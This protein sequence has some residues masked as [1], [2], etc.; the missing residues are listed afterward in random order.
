[1]ADVLSNFRDVTRNVRLEKEV[2]DRAERMVAINQIVN[3][4]NSSIEAGRVY[5]NLTREVR[6]LVNFDY[7]AVSLYMDDGSFETRQL[8]PEPREGREQFPRMDD[9]E[10]CSGWV[11]KEKRCLLIPLLEDDASEFARNFPED[12]RSCLCVPLHAENKIIGS[13]NFGSRKEAGF[14]EIDARMLEQMSPHLAA[15]IRNGKLLEDL[16]RTLEEATQAR[17]KLHAANEE[18]KSLDEM[19][20]NLLSNVS[21]ELRT[22]LVAVMGYTDMVLNGK[23]GP[24]TETQREYLQITLRNV[25][26]LVSLIENLLDFSRLHKGTEEMVFTRFNLVDCIHASMQSVKPVADG[27]K[28]ELLLSIVNADNEEGAASLIVEGDKGKLGQVFNNLLANAVKFN[29]NGGKVSVTIEVRKDA[30]HIAVSDTG[31][32]IEENDLD[33]VFARFYQCDASSTRK[34]GGTG[35]G[36]AIAQDIIRLHGSRITV[37]SKVGEGST[38]RFTLPLYMPSDIPG[39]APDTSVLPVETRLLVEVV[40]RDKALSAQIRNFLQSEGMDIIHAL[41]AETALMM[42]HKY[43][44]DCILVDTEMDAS[45]SPVLDAIVESSSEIDS[46]IIM[47]TDD[48]TLYRKYEGHVVAHVKRSFRK[49]TLLSGIH[50][51][52]SHGAPKDR[53]LG[54]KILCVDDDEEI[55]IF[56]ARCL[57]NEGYETE[58]CSTGERALAL[59]ATREYWLVLL[60]V[61]IPDMDGWTVCRN[62]KN[63]ADLAGIKVYI[64]TAKSVENEAH[65]IRD[66]EADGYLLKPFKAD[67]IISVVRA[68][69][70]QSGYSRFI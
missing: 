46:A 33:K 18:L 70:A 40:S 51:A 47:I 8:W 65:E 58:Y 55:G 13:L 28:I 37:T 12:I 3:V 20:T 50:L 43:N 62:L 59:A 1:M 68:F 27:R 42:I 22:P 54:K 25:E 2:S 63:N 4:V 45:A 17:E 52:L 30:A 15:A 49:S 35:I 29:K 67:D 36:L 56:I 7:A 6:W 34:Y 53:Q 44:P 41:S 60:D 66:S 10:S 11:S 24:T 19:K 48:D 32:G 31:I 38:F 39:V 21:H 23:A 9:M 26:K 69:D 14:S 64:V 61:A 57:E 16:T 5:E